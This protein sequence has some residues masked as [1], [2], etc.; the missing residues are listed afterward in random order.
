MHGVYGY[1]PGNHTELII[2]DAPTKM[3]EFFQIQT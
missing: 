1:T 3:V 2:E